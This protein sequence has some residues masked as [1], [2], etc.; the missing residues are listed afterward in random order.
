[1]QGIRV[2]RPRAVK[3][4]RLNLDWLTS[5]TQTIRFR[6]ALWSVIILGLVLFV[7][8]ALVY[9]SRERAW[10]VETQSQ[11]QAQSEKLAL[12]YELNDPEAPQFRSRNIKADHEQ[13]VQE[14]QHLV[15]QNEILLIV[16]DRGQIAQNLGNFT[17]GDSNQLAELAR[18][19]AQLSS[20][21]PLDSQE[22]L[23]RANI[24]QQTYVFYA[25]PVLSQSTNAG[26]LLL[27][28]EQDPSGQQQR[29]LLAL[30]LAT[31]A[32]LL[33]ALVCGYWLAGQAMRP[34]QTIARA[35]Q[36]ISATDLNR[37]LQLDSPDEL[38]ELAATFNRMLDRLQAAFDHQRRFTADASHELRTPL[39]IVNMEAQ[40]AL[41]QR[42]SPEEYE[43][44]LSIIQAETEHMTRLVN[45]LLTLARADAGQAVLR[46]ERLDL[47]DLTLDVIERLA[48]LAR[49]NG[50]VLV[51]GEL[52]ELVICGDRLYLTQMLMN[53]V[54]NAIKYT[55]E[56]GSR[57]WIETGRDLNDYTSQGWIRIRDDGPG[58]SAEHLAHL[59]D[60][61]YKVDAARFWTEETQRGSFV[62]GRTTGG[63]GLGLSIA[64]W[65]AQAHGG[66]VNV[67]SSRGE[68]S[69]FEVRL[70]LAE[71]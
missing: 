13:L 10:Q 43:Q 57:V 7:F 56:I 68:G 67:E 11:L 5:H 27:G 6:L 53:L 22:G 37:R 14:Q 28:R 70:P 41:A 3:W 35:V 55:R 8:S 61:F 2:A 40:R 30:L 21:L 4:P 66:R 50:I 46:Q 16:N 62:D 29:L 25:L 69:V 45:D 36:E 65:V 47:S 32:T 20:Q 63:S 54:E 44:A 19:A 59:F 12:L 38:G 15:A 31:P 18:R 51:A 49:E 60:R 1:M 24:G 42:R 64:Q 9:T 17:N 71:N 58:I 39:A 48:P 26:V 52:P 34:V 33:I 23:F